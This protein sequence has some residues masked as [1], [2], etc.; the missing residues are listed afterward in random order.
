MRGDV[1]ED[2]FFDAGLADEA[3]AALGEITDAAVKQATGPT[4]RA[5]SK[6]MLLDQ[7]NAQPTH[8]GIA[9]D[10]R[11]DNPT[12]NDEDVEVG[13]GQSLK[14]ALTPPRRWT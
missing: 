12:A 14:C 8:G 5:K 11:A 9:G 1:V 3:D 2:S 10:A 6:I 13:L 4:A 7:T